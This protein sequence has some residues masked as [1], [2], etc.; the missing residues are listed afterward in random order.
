MWGKKRKKKKDTP[1]DLIGRTYL[2]RKLLQSVGHTRGR[3]VPAPAANDDGEVR[4]WAAVVPR[5]DLDARGFTDGVVEGIRDGCGG[6]AAALRRS[7]FGEPLGGAPGETASGEHLERETARGGI[8][9]GGLWVFRLAGE[10]EDCL[11]DREPTAAQR[12]GSAEL[13]FSRLETASTRAVGSSHHSL[14]GFLL[15][16][17]NKNKN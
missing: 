10:G 11:R 8:S 4:G 17:K 16:N 6:H 9:E 3:L 1:P 15:Q 14:R 7:G 2:E 12:I 5:C 13:E